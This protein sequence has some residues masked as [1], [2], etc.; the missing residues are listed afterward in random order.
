M[1]NEFISADTN[2][3]HVHIPKTGGTSLNA[4]FHHCEW[5]IN[6]EHSF[7]EVNFPF[8]GKRTSDGRKWSDFN[9]NGFTND[10]QIIAV[11][12]NPFDWLKS[13]YLHEGSSFKGLIK[14]SGW[15]G[16]NDFHKFG[17]FSGF[18]DSYIDSD[19]TWHVP[20]LHK[21]QLGQLRGISENPSV[22]SPI[23]IFNEYLDDFIEELSLIKGVNLQKKVRRNVSPKTEIL[24]YTAH[25]I[26][27][28]K[29]KMAAFLALTGYDEFGFYR[30]PT[31][32]FIIN[33]NEK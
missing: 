16:C 30:A 4:T 33:N 19:F 14:H 11:I 8:Y 21:S 20:P 26:T 7:Y 31:K 5:F 9:E 24:S 1:L 6:G 18:V 17:S 2:V 28:L 12:R 32:S 22:G 13:Y 23:L 25:Q 15:H 3:F 27:G 10:M 29:N